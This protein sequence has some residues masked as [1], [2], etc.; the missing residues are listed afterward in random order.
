MSQ[1]ARAI[2]NSRLYDRFLS[3]L[4]DNPFY[5]WYA[6][7]AVVI[8]ANSVRDYLWQQ[9]HKERRITECV[10][11]PYETTFVEFSMPRN[12]AEPLNIGLLCTRDLQPTDGIYNL[13]IHYVDDGGYFG[14]KA[15]WIVDINEDGF[16]V[17]D[18]RFSHPPNIQ[19]P[20][21]IHTYPSVALMTFALMHCKNIALNEVKPK[22]KQ[23][24][25]FN[26]QY[27]KPLVSYWTLMI[28]STL[29]ANKDNVAAPYQ[30]LMPLHL[31]RGH[32]A[33]YTDDKPL[34]GKYVGTFWK[35]ATMVGELS[36]GV[37]I[38][39]YKVKPNDKATVQR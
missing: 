16:I 14:T 36:N 31:R 10:L 33:T 1:K 23:S 5:A 15:F 22:D 11:P 12:N 19:Y 21:D 38:K 2:K 26:K 4:S 34:F 18:I 24:H 3:T 25:I 7:E 37:V 35:E 28:Q 9:T 20:T 32:F 27:G 13:Y 6:S 29:K 39:D 17:G 30:G 8:D